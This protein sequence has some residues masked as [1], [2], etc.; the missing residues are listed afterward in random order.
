[1]NVPP[2]L[3]LPSTDDI[4]DGYFFVLFHICMFSEE[5]AATVLVLLPSLLPPRPVATLKSR[6]NKW[7]PSIAEGRKGFIDLQKV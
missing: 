1:M 3:K 4:Y 2:L 7:K 5:I 6:K